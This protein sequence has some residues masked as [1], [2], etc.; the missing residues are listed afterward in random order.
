MGERGRDGTTRSEREN[1]KREKGDAM[2]KVK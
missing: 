1:E 2:E